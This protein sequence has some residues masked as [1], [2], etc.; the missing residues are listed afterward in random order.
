MA[1]PPGIAADREPDRLR[2]EQAR[3]ALQRGDLNRFER[4]QARLSDYVLFPYLRYAYLRRYLGSRVKHGE[5]VEFLRHWGDS[6]LAERLRG[7]WLDRLGR[8]SRWSEYLEIF[9]P[10]GDP[11][12]ACYAGRALLAS[13]ERERAMAAAERLWMVG[14]S[15]PKACDPLFAAWMADGG[16][17][18]DRARERI[19][20]AIE[21]GQPALTRYLERFVSEKERHWVARWRRIHRSPEREL[22]RLESDGVWSG[23]LFASGVRQLARRDALAA[24]A[25]WRA[26]AGEFPL[27]GRERA[28]TARFLA[29]VLAWNHHPPAKER[30]AELPDDWHNGESRAWAVR[31]ALWEQ[32]WDA[33][34]AAL[35]R[36]TP[37]ERLS[38]EWRYW[39]ARTLMALGRSEEADALYRALADERSYYG[40]LAAAQAGGPPRIESVPLTV[41]PEQMAAV[42]RLPAMQRIEELLALGMDW[43]ARREWWALIQR[44]PVGALTGAAKLAD[45]WG[46][47]DQ[48]I[49]ALGRAQFLDDLEIRFPTPYES[50]VSVEAQRRELDQA[51]IY[52]VMRQESAFFPHARSSAG[53]LGLM[54]LMPTT[55]RL[56]ARRL[57]QSAPGRWELL[58]VDTNIRL[59]A[60]H[61][62]HLLD[63]YEGNRL[64]AMAAY[65]AGPHR[66]SAWLPK[67]QVLPGDI[68]VDCLPF[69]ETREYVKRVFAYTLIY[70]WRLGRELTPVST[71]LPMIGPDGPVRDLAGFDRSGT[72]S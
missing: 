34:L 38:A 61:L 33:A 31:S 9:E 44:L 22:R 29:L 16:V 19:R 62:R 35:E 47:H 58:T 57:K 49:I 40:F 26:R 42:A 37:E 24:D 53:A 2:F 17:T 64:Y 6:P 3:A 30:L 28:G 65:N 60:A 69:D 18:A 52:A 15:Q 67:E 59:G 27:K 12:R 21:A 39:R 68:W 36:L 56:T 71:H 7:A 46:W 5:V 55:A 43:D 72:A 48:A 14:V 63:R 32:D 10:D 25:I 4:L 20:L 8:R 54:Q 1:L 45:G 23:L 50:R 51:F 13:G 41:P 11:E 66:V 70:E